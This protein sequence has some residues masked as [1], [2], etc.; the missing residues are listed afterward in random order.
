MKYGVCNI[1]T[2]TMYDAIAQRLLGKKKI[3]YCKVLTLYMK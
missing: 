3:Y 1:Y 2:G